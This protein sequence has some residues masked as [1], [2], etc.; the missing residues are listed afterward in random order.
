MGAQIISAA[1]YFHMKQT[2]R[3]VYAD[4]S[5]FNQPERLAVVGNTGDCTH[6]GWQL[7]PF[8]LELTSFETN[9]A[10]N[11]RNARVIEDGVEKL[12]LA[13]KALADP[14]VRK[15]FAVP[16]GPVDPS[17]AEL[18]GDYLCIHV[19]RGDYVN[20]SSHLVRDEEFVALAA[21]FAGLVKSVVVL[22]DSPISEALKT[23]VARLFERSSFLDK[24]DAYVAH[25]IMRGSRILV[26]SNS[27][28][29]L[30]AAMLNPQA[31]LV[32]PKQWFG[33]ELRALEAPLGALCRF[34]LIGG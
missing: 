30:I 33:E 23:D 27:Q 25:R 20:V 15:A 8:G 13:L 26:C 6:W 17:D 21:R 19:R 1:I 2:G 16:A 9:P 22:S 34:Q 29:S 32:I 31:L 24:T 10:L 5:Y 12:E 7:S 3:S 18:Q 28:F 4:L 14:D 11:K